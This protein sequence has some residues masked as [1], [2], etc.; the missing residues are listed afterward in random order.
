M[1]LFYSEQCCLLLWKAWKRFHQIKH[2]EVQLVHSCL[3][4][5]QAKEAILRLQ[6][7]VTLIWHKSRLL[8]KDTMELSWL[9]FPAVSRFWLWNSYCCMVGLI[10]SSQIMLFFFFGFFFVL[11]NLA[12]SCMAY[13]GC[14][15]MQVYESLCCPTEVPRMSQLRQRRRWTHHS[16]R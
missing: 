4:W 1:L 3:L 7:R 11:S 6:Q 13:L 16:W 12:S 14:L 8:R 15:A 5:R 10:S 9:F 2:S